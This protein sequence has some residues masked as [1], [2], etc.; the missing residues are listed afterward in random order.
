MR[1]TNLEATMQIKIPITKELID[2][3][4]IILDMSNIQDII[5]STKEIPVIIP[6]DNQ[7]KIIGA[8]TKMTYQSIDNQEYIMCDCILNVNGG[9]SETV[10]DSDKVGFKIKNFHSVGFCIE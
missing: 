2:D 5:K 4:G 7:D 3:N 9:T 6:V 8:C 10:E 1:I